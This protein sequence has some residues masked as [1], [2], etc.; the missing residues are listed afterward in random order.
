VAHFFAGFLIEIHFR[1]VMLLMAVC[2]LTAGFVVWY[3]LWRSQ[4]ASSS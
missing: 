3:V 1:F 2:G 4:A